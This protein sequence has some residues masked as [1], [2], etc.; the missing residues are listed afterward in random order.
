[1][2]KRPWYIWF[3]LPAFIALWGDTIRRIM[4]VPKGSLNIANDSKRL[5]L[6][7][8]AIGHMFS[9]MLILTLPLL[10][11]SLLFEL[12]VGKIPELQLILVAIFFTVFYLIGVFVA[13]R[14]VIWREKNLPK[15]NNQDN[16]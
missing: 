15:K 8:R 11:I 6:W 3:S 1:M 12:I 9:S 4:V 5:S 13:Y 16:K 7:A 2:K 14:F 10:A